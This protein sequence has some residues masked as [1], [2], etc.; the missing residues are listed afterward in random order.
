MNVVGDHLA[1]HTLDTEKAEQ[2]RDRLREDNIRWGK[3]C[4]NANKWQLQLQT[5]LMEN[6]EFHQTI[7]ELCAWLEKTESQIRA[8]E[9]V[10]LTSEK[11][12]ID[13]KYQ[14]FKRL[15]GDLE[16]CEPRVVSL[17]EAANYLL[18]SIE[19]TSDS[20]KSVHTR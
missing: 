19:S 16:R 13:N 18:K 6:K 8:T 10:D 11:S 14:K 3:V 2:L 1:T 15:H 5:S 20:S 17:Q 4:V 12:V 7:E 9:P